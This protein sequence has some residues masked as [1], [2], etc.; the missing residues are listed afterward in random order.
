[1]VL[2]AIP[3]A[4]AGASGLAGWL[5]GKSKKDTSVETHAAYEHYQ[6]T[7]TE[8]AK[9]QHF[10]PRMVHA[11]VSSYVVQEGDIF[12]ES[13]GA[14]SKKEAQIDQESRPEISGAIDYA[15]ETA[16]A[17][18]EGEGDIAGVNLTHIA[19][20]AATGMIGYGLISKP[21]KGRGKK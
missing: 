8:A 2:P 12:I 21:V 3:L 11:P 18:R 13:P 9:F 14:K 19:L 10:H 20:I 15:T 17:T 1:M 7:I 6:P 16:G 4:L 5:A